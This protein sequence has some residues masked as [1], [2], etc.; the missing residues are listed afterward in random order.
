MH[1]TTWDRSDREN[2]VLLAE[3]GPERLAVFHT[4]AGTAEVGQSA[5]SLTVD[6]TSAVAVFGDVNAQLTGRRSR[7]KRLVARV[8]K[9][10]YAFI[11]EASSD[12]VIVAGSRQGME[13]EMKVAQ[14]SGKNSGVRKAIVEFEG[15]AA[16]PREDIVALSWFARLILEDKVSSSS[17]AIIATLTLASIVAVAAFL[18]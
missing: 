2:P 4:V 1:Y 14:F 3:E 17:A 16:V 7:D 9:R 6:S 12:W 15:E 10:E 11:N 18:L 5:W 8:A 13:G